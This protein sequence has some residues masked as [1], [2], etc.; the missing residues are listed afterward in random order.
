MTNVNSLYSTLEITL[1][2]FIADAS[3]KRSYC[4][5]YGQTSGTVSASGYSYSFT[6]L[7]D[8]DGETSRLQTVYTDLLDRSGSGSQAAWKQ[9]KE[10]AL[11]VIDHLAEQ[12]LFDNDSYSNIS[13]EGWTRRPL[14]ALQAWIEFCDK[15]I[16]EEAIAET[17][18]LGIVVGGFNYGL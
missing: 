18:P 17:L 9:R 5:L 6:S 8:L 3:Q 12:G 10:N 13:G 2:D 7:V 11:R 15:K 16:T 4:E 1:R 14:S